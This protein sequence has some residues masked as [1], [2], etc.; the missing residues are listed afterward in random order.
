MTFNGNCN[1]CL[2]QPQCGFCLPSS[3]Y[4]L[5]NGPSCASIYETSVCPG[6]WIFTC[7][8][9]SAI[10]QLIPN[11]AP[12]SSPVTVQVQ[13][14]HFIEVGVYECQYRGVRF[15]ADLTNGTVTCTLNSPGAGRSLLNLLVDGQQYTDGFSFEFYG[16]L[17]LDSYLTSQD[18]DQGNSQQNCSFCSVNP[19]SYCGWCLSQ[20]ACGTTE[21]CTDDTWVK[22]C[23]GNSP[24]I[25]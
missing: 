24:T 13:G 10:T 17:L 23:P 8:R 20:S 11:H 19:S 15:P 5:T 21:N 4:E 9:I 3:C 16:N 25:V 7:L 6:K 22:S 14:G 2:S 18:C 12:V 1:G